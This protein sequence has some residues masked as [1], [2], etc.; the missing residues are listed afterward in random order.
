MKKTSKIPA[1]LLALAMTAGM[2]AG[3]GSDTPKESGDAAQTQGAQ[4]A[5]AGGEKKTFVFGDTTFNAENE[6][7]N[8]DPHSAYCGWAC[9]RYGVGETLMKIN[10]DMTLSP[11]VAEGFEVVDY[12]TWKITV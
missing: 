3:C 5:Q 12:L 11:W 1:L 4:D 9:M 8:I 7:Y 6:E 2:L 10:D